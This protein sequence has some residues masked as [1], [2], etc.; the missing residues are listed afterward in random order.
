MGFYPSA[1][2]RLPISG[3]AENRSRL[4]LLRPFVSESYCF[5]KTLTTNSYL[6]LFLKTLP[7]AP[8]N[9]EL[10]GRFCGRW[11]NTAWLKSG[12]KDLASGNRIGSVTAKRGVSAW[13]AC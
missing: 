9:L 6:R 3:L 7:S 10:M 2:L 1:R 5:F 13:R 8:D 12:C 11:L 4:R